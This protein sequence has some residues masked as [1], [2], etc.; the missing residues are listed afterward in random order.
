M[1]PRSSPPAFEQ[2]D[3]RCRLVAAVAVFNP[4][5]TEAGGQLDFP[6]TNLHFHFAPLGEARAADMTQAGDARDECP[7]TRRTKSSARRGAIG[8][9]SRG[10]VTPRRGGDRLQQAASMGQPF[11]QR[12]LHGPPVSPGNQTPPNPRAARRQSARDRGAAGEERR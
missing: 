2:G 3:L 1:A 12:R 11:P 5:Q 7:W 9:V 10:G 8:K 4:D 6:V